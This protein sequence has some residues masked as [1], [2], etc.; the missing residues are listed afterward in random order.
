MKR[1]L[2]LMLILCVVTAYAFSQSRT[3]SGQV[4]DGSG[5]PVIG[6][7]VAI[8][9]ESVG[10]I[11]DL[12][13][14]FILKFT[15]SKGMLIQVSFVGMVTKEL[16]PTNATNYQVILED[17]TQT[18]EQV[19]VVGY[20]TVKKSDLT[21]SVESIKADKLTMGGATNV[22]QMLQGRVAGLYIS[23]H[24]QD[25]GAPSEIMLRGVGSLSSSSQPLIVIDGFPSSDTSILNTINPS[26]I[27]Q[28]DILK[29]ASATA[30][31][32]SRGANGVIIITTK[33]GRK[34]EKI[35]IDYG[36]KLSME[37]VARKVDVMNSEEYIRY[38]YDLAHDADY[39]LNLPDG[40]KGKKYPYPLESIGKVADTDWQQELTKQ[41]RITQNHNLSISGGTESLS[42]RVSFNYYD[43]NGIVKPYNYRRFNM[44]SKIAYQKKRFGFNADLSYTKENSNTAK[45]SYLNALRFSP[46]VERHDE[47]GSLSLFPISSVEWFNNPFYNEE[48]I[49]SNNEINTTRFLVS[50]SYEI[51]KGLKIEG[52]VGFER[53]FSEGYSYQNA[54]S[55]SQDTGGITNGNTTN[56][57]LDAIATYMNSWNKH[58]FSTMVATNYQTF[59]GRGNSMS[60]QGFSSSTIRYYS[61]SGVADKLNRDISSYW[62][63]SVNQSFLSR[64]AYDYNNRYYLTFNYRLDGASQ[65]GDHNKLGHFPSVAAAWKINN[66]KFFGTHY[67][68]N[69]KLKLGYGLSG[70]A[71]VPAG[72]SQAL[73]SYIPVY[74][75]STIK[76]GITWNGGYYPNPDLRWE[77]AKTFNVGIEAGGK[78][79][80]VDVNAYRKHSY[81]LLI[82]RPLPIE[83]GYG[84]ITLNKGEVIN[85]GVE[86]KVDGYLNFLG[87][88][89]NWYPSFWLA[90]NHNNLEKFDG[91]KVPTLEVWEDKTSMGYTGMMQEGYPMGALFGYDYSGVWQQNEAAEA[92]VY[93]A[94]PGDPKFL[95]RKTVKSNGAIVDGPDG[96]IDDADKRYLGSTYPTI[97]LGF[98]S[99]LRYKEWSLSFMLD[100]VLNRK[101][102]NYN[103]LYMLNPQIVSYGNLS[104]EALQRWT[105][106]RPNTEIPSFTRGI[107]KNLVA[108]TFCIEDASFCRLREVTLAYQHDFEAQLFIRSF[109]VYITGT[110]LATITGYKGLNP[111][112]TGL[113]TT[114]NLQPIP[115]TY[116]LGINLTF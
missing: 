24:N 55:F 66:E 51:V 86:A 42:Y 1:T 17:D 2:F 58:N 113:D 38:Y 101:A 57:N 72:R 4:Q 56:L 21:G 49:D 71:N 88:K 48:N 68:N 31:Y 78:H 37:T 82:D 11:T 10:T 36:T 35:A 20:G 91:S 39:A 84:Q 3:I 85:Y 112:I 93:G 59:R 114:W 27:E 63:E 9:G 73:I 105:P 81:D 29:D 15:Q 7:N 61:M 16:H 40:Y 115:R 110:N 79:F 13:G 33:K 47:T 80:T 107:D 103:R 100:G 104:R 50:A 89:L 19:V 12:D 102:V 25:P 14:K 30:I 43:G 75:G 76:N 96:V 108:S 83:T 94:H 77:G 41:N 106:D 64:L 90:Y 109:K 70:N 45:N 62:N 65:F 34:G 74:L 92:A 23:S 69:L 116:L 54:T 99:T 53:K 44:M 5:Q 52:R 95:D 97:T 22:A 60:G 98:S 32:G 8:K 6:A 18:L 111:D 46:T 26:D 67:I 87:G 28:M